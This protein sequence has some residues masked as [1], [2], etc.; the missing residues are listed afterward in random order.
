MTL[1]GKIFIYFNLV[2]SAL[3]AVLGLLLYA[4]YL[5]PSGEK[6]PGEENPAGLI[7]KQQEKIRVAVTGLPQAKSSW[8]EAR[9]VLL[10]REDQRRADEA[11]YAGEL[12]H[13]LTEATQAKP[14]RRVVINN[15][16]LPELDPTNAFRP[17]MVAVNDRSGQ[18]LEAL[19]VYDAR[20]KE[21]LEK[22]QMT[23][24]AYEK[25]IQEDIELTNKLAGTPEMKG[26]QQRLTDERFKREG[27]VA[28]QLL[29]E[30]F[31]KVA[32]VDTQLLRQRRESIDERLAELTGY[33]RRQHKVEITRL[34]SQ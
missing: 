18:P 21:T 16:N 33:L 19:S 22:L 7:G 34:G 29:V 13:L 26:L 14:G 1:I 5:D 10:A 6:R 31:W 32:E 9:K 12:R 30:P 28:E 24:A 20:S 25:K 8:R 3:L 2:A 23:L 27:V 4:N 17:K 11:W 15:R